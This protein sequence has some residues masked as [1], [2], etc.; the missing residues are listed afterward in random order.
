MRRRLAANLPFDGVEVANP[1]QRF[2]RQWCAV[3]L[4]NLVELATCVRPTG[5]KDDFVFRGQ[6]L[7]A[8]VA[9]YRRPYCAR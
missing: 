6:P 1:A 3:G 9:I 7:E 2:Q 5:G 4:G 8:G